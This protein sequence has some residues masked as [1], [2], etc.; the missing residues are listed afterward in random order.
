MRRSTLKLLGNE[1]NCGTNRFCFI[2]WFHILGERR[3]ALD[4]VLARQSVVAV[5]SGPHGPTNAW[6]L[7]VGLSGVQ[8]SEN[9]ALGPRGA[10]EL[11]FPIV[12]RLTG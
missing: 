10:P 6:K 8:L 5:P 2:V 12:V 11:D 3:N 9:P 7:I 4:V 1:P